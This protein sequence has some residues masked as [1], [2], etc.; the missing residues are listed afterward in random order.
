MRILNLIFVVLCCLNNTTE[1]HHCIWSLIFW[2]FCDLGIFWKSL[3]SSSLVCNV[4]MM[5][6]FW[7]LKFNCGTNPSFSVT[8]D[9]T[10]CFQI[11]LCWEFI[12]GF[13]V[14]WITNWRFW[15][16]ISF[17]E[18][19]TVLETMIL[20]LVLKS[21]WDIETYCLMMNK[22]MFLKTIYLSG[23]L[24]INTCYPEFHSVCVVLSTVD[25][26]ISNCKLI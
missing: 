4:L 7:K 9:V 14:W 13:G 19:F 20:V 25:Q 26:L 21:Y 24:T 1:I 16:L 12:F 23:L 8:Y 18:Y 3:L 5:N 2:V 17:L 15:N 22:A 10:A 6:L 11:I